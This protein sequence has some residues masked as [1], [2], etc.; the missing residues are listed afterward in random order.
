MYSSF[1]DT[2]NCDDFDAWLQQE[3]EEVVFNLVVNDF[4]RMLCRMCIDEGKIDKQVL[5]EIHTRM[6]E[7][8][9]ARGYLRYPFEP[10][11]QH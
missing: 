6:R 11:Q 5:M 3:K 7:L 4:N 9:R 10:Q 1:C 2:C 8:A